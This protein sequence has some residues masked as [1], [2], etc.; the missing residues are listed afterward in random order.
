LGDLPV[1]GD[2]GDAHQLGIDI[3][4]WYVFPIWDGLRQQEKHF[5]FGGYHG[6]DENGRRKQLSNCWEH[7]DI[8]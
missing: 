8:V 1:L 2:L 6:T 4:K 5:F 3:C 7:S